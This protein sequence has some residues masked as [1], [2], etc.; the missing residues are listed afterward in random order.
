[1]AALIEEENLDE[2]G[3][4]QVGKLNKRC[5]SSYWKSEQKLKPSM[6]TATIGNADDEDKDDRDYSASN[7]DH[8]SDSSSESDGDSDVKMVSNDELADILPPKTAP[9]T[10]CTKSAPPKKK[11][12]KATIKEV[13]DEDCPHNISVHNRASPELG[14]SVPGTSA[15]MES[16]GKKV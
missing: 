2:D 7:S 4:V 1:M 3:N 13:E 11:S 6:S 10:Q 15:N 16:T 12:C 9:K 14:T 5:I 8:K